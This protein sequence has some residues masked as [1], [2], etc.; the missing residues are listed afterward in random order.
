MNTFTNVQTII[1]LFTDFETTT[2]TNVGTVLVTPI[3]LKVQ[4]VIYPIAQ[5]KEFTIKYTNG[6]IVNIYV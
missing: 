5:V 2:V 3:M 1:I 6:E 4:G